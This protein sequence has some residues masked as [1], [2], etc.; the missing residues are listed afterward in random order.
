MT[1]PRSDGRAHPFRV[2]HRP[3]EALRGYEAL[4]GAA[5]RRKHALDNHRGRQERDY[6]PAARG[7]LTTPAG[8]R[9]SVFLFFLTP[10][11]NPKENHHDHHRHSQEIPSQQACALRGKRPQ[12][13]Q[14]AFCRG[15]RRQ[16]PGARL[17]AE[18]CRSKG[19]REIR[20][21]RRRPAPESADA[22]CEGRRYQGDL[23]RYVQ[24]CRRGYRRRR[25]QPCRKRGARGHAPR[26]PVRGIP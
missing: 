18:P 2:S 23:S 12:N 16:H 21:C 1:W 6:V 25:N 20:R 11:P 22:A 24:N 7:I 5:Q 19:R 14:Q 9:F 8:G 4:A 10:K 17:A 26:R 3:R 13:A 15:T